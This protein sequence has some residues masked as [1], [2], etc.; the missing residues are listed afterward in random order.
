MAEEQQVAANAAAAT[1]SANSAADV[2]ALNEKAGVAGK[3][4]MGT[5]KN[6]A[7]ALATEVDNW[8]ME[9][10]HNTVLARE[11]E[12]YNYL[13]QTVQSLKARLAKVL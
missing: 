10:I 12:S 8:F 4:L 3:E 13:R 1:K 6:N 9:E 5:T 11:T 7:S 2:T